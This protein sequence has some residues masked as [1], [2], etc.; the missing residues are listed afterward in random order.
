[1]ERVASW[2][3]FSQSRVRTNRLQLQQERWRPVIQSKKRLGRPWDGQFRK[4]IQAPLYEVA[5]KKPLSKEIQ[6]ESCLCGMDYVMN[7]VPRV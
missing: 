1:M 2:F 7:Y 5:G 4:V 3:L 6:V